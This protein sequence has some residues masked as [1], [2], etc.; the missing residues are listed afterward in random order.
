MSGRIKRMAAP[1]RW[2][3]KRK[4]SYW[5]AK[6]SPGPHGLEY[7]MPLISVVRDMLSL[8]GLAKEGRKLI[9]QGSFSVDGKVRNDPNYPVGLMDVLTV[10]G[11]EGG[12]RMLIDRRNRLHL[13]PV[14]KEEV[15]W[16]LCRVQGRHMLSGGKKQ[17]T[18]HDGRTIVS[19]LDART[20]DVV[21]LEIPAQR[22]SE[23]YRLAPGSKALITGGS[24]V[25]QLATVKTFEKWRNPAPNLVHFEEGFST[26]WT[27]VFVSGATSSVI[28]PPE[29][30]AI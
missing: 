5:A 3:V 2:P 25:G 15:S 21:R 11:E 18:F 20:G 16:K 10:K 8:V 22:V 30:S 27:N 23:V 14:G 13:V 9:A 7:S 29:V 4:E 17:L 28:R 24:H 1:Y 12:F 19:D 26:V 6:P